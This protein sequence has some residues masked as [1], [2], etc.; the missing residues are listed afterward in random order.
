MADRP[1]PGGPHTPAP[2]CLCPASPQYH[3]L[4]TLRQPGGLHQRQKFTERRTS[5]G[6]PLAARSFLL[7]LFVLL[8]RS[9]DFLPPPGRYQQ[10]PDW[11]EET[12]RNHKLRGIYGHQKVR[13]CCCS[14]WCFAFYMT[15]NR[16]AWGNFLQERRLGSR[17]GRGWFGREVIFLPT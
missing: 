3:E 7:I 4:A 16:K 1:T 10:V 14:C 9:S 2:F 15:V 6:R 5:P 17:L 12:R 8:L 11:M 13:L